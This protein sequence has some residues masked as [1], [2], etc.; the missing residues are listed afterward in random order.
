MPPNREASC[1]SPGGFIIHEFRLTDLNPPA[2]RVI[3]VLERIVAWRG[4]LR[5]LRMDNGPEFISAALAEWSEDHNIDLEFIQPG[6]PTQ[7]AC[8]ERFNCTYRDEVHNMCML[9]TL[10]EPRKITGKMGTAK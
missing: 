1:H 3:Q 7:N 9:C 10:N 2:Q 6:K 4:Y 5:K 8:V